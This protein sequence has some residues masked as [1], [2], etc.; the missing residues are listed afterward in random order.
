MSVSTNIFSAQELKQ[1]ERIASDFP[2]KAYLEDLNTYRGK[3]KTF[4][5]NSIQVDPTFSKLINSKT[6]IRRGKGLDVDKL[7]SDITKG[8]EFHGVRFWFN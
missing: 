1:I 2:P 3:V 7:W 8:A 4:V 6:Y 5:L